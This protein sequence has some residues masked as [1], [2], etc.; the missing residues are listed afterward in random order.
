MSNKRVTI[1]LPITFDTSFG[2]FDRL[3]EDSATADVEFVVGR[4]EVRIRA[5]S[6]IL[7]AASPVFFQLFR[8]EWK[9]YA[10]QP[11]IYLSDVDSEAFRTLLI[12]IYKDFIELDMN[13][14]FHVLKAAKRFSIQAITDNLTSDSTFNTHS[15]K[16]VWQY[17]SFSVLQNNMRMMDKCLEIIDS[18]AEYF[19]SMHDFTR[20]SAKVISIVVSRDS[21]VINESRLFNFCLKWC[22]RNA[23]DNSYLWIQ[24]TNEKSWNPSFTTFAFQSWS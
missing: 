13:K 10:I 2:R 7:K 4:R 1:S 5:H 11:E 22:K 3:L 8:N 16:S 23:K 21:L 24:S 20:V 17:L 12:Y 6:N 14:L 9:D 19:L 18:D 15:F